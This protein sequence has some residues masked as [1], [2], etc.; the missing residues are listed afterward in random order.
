MKV[1]GLEELVSHDVLEFCYCIRYPKNW[2]VDSV[3]VYDDDFYGLSPY[4][5]QVIPNYPYYAPQEVTVEQWDRIER[6]ALTDGKFQEFFQKVREWKSKDPA[7]SKSFWI[8]GI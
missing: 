1:M 8:L 2:N 5:E 4:L 6:L 3:F 7:G